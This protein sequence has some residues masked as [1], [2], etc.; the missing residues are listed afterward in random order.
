MFGKLVFGML[1]VFV[2]GVGSAL[3]AQNTG[4]DKQKVTR[5]SMGTTLNPQ[6]LPPG[7]RRYYSRHHRRHHSNGT[8]FKPNYTR[9][10]KA[11]GVHSNALTVKQK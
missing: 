6:P 3:M 11:R 10:K 8:T 4:G 1:L 9:Y 5:T 7:K 2:L